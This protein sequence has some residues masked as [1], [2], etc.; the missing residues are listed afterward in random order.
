MERIPKGIYNPEFREQAVPLYEMDKLTLPEDS[1]AL[2]F[3][4]RHTK[5]LDLCAPPRQVG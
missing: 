5:G 3:T 1:K 4:A 2:I